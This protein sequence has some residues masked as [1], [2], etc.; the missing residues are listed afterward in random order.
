MVVLLRGAGRVDGRG[1]TAGWGGVDAAAGDDGRRAGGAGV[2]VPGEAADAAVR[3]EDPVRGA[4]AQ[5]REAAAH[6]GPVREAQL[7]A[8]AAEAP[9][10]KAA[11]PTLVQ[12]LAVNKL[13]KQLHKIEKR[14]Q[15]TASTTATAAT[16]GSLTILL[17]GLVALLVGIIVGSGFLTTIGSIVAVVG[18]I[19]LLLK[20][21]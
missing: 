1:R 12:R 11:K 4:Q 18:L 7:A 6:E 3:Q 16:S 9:A 13:T 14:Q 5:R 17:V 20:A 10:V 8:A 19:L 15:N 2:A 21:L